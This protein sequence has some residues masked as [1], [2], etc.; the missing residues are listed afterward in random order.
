MIK[1]ASEIMNVKKLKGTL[2]IEGHTDWTGDEEYNQILSE[3]RAKAVEEVFKENVTNENINYETKGY[4]E[5]RP[6][7]DNK[8]KEGRAAN[9]RVEMKLNK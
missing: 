9:R 4:G 8:T 5:T 6:V 3:K 1:N 7:A 2:S